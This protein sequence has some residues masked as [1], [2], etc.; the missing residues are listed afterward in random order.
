MS[1][2]TPRL[3]INCSS[4][5]ELQFRSAPLERSP[6]AD[7]PLAVTCILRHPTGRFEYDVHHLYFAEADLTKFAAELRG[8]QQ[9]ASA[10]ATLRN[11][12]EMFM[13]RLERKGRTLRATLNIREYIPRD[14]SA[15]LSF[16][17]EVDYDLFV[18][19]LPEAVE[20]FVRDL[21]EAG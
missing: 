10:E 15:S 2:D 1:L 19:K 18:N 5:F 8:V 7:H 6:A 3:I 12:G 16:A 11:S 17:S 9:G 4:D 14:G 20:H 21:R 13:F